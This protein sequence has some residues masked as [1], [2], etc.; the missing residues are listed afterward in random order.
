MKYLAWSALLPA[1]VAALS[2]GSAP[3]AQAADPPD[4][5]TNQRVLSC[6]GAPVE[7]YLTPAG[8]GSAFHVVGSTDIIKPKHVEVVFP[9]GTG[10]VT[11]V[12][13]PGFNRNGLDTV[14]CTYTDP[15]GL[16]VDFVGVR[17]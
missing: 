15:A 5:W 16:F 7:T 8:F 2:M 13:T 11:T 10:P 4:S 9:D 6:D 17:R 12:D 14:H 1:A 3:S